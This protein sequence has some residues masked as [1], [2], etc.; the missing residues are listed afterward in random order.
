MTSRYGKWRSHLAGN[1]DIYRLG[2]EGLRIFGY[3]PMRE[4]PDPSMAADG[5]YVCSLSA[6]QCGIKNNAP[7][8]VEEAVVVKPEEWTLSGKCETFADIDYFGGKSLSSQYI[9]EFRDWI[10]FII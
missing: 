6:D 5:G 8:P 1:K 10:Q 2:S 7:V 4:V 3:E 9:L